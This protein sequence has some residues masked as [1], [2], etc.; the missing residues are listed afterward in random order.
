[1]TNICHTSCS[2]LIPSDGA[3]KTGDSTITVRLQGNGRTHKSTWWAELNTFCTLNMKI[4]GQEKTRWRLT[5]NRGDRWSAPWVEDILT[6]AKEI[7]LIGGKNTN[8]VVM[9]TSCCDDEDVKE[10]MALK[11]R[12]KWLDRRTFHRNAIILPKCRRDLEPVAQE[13][14]LYKS[15]KWF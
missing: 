7:R 1:M 12:R 9:N 2:R 14:A 8:A 13:C 15:R 6:I 5:N 4:K 10:L 11:L 3:L